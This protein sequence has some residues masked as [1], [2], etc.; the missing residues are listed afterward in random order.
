MPGQWGAGVAEK[1]QGQN[2]TYNSLDIARQTNVNNLNDAIQNAI[3]NNDL[4]IYNAGKAEF[5]RA[6]NQIGTSAQSAAT[7]ADAILRFKTNDAD[8]MARIAAEER[9]R[10]D[11][12]AAAKLKA[13]EESNLRRISEAERAFDRDNEALV[14]RKKLE[15]PYTLPPNETPALL[16]QR[17][18]QI[19]RQKHLEFGV[20]L[21]P[22]ENAG[23]P[24][25]KENPIKLG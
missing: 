24:G 25:T 13:G 14:I 20:P 10:G 11:T 22:S 9:M 6:E 15:N 17:L 19:R 5:T 12:L 23:A 2:E 4:S 8:R 21:P 7:M 1:V 3:M 18:E 16:N